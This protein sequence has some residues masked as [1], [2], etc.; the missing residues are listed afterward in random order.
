MVFSKY[1]S[2]NCGCFKLQL[3]TVFWMA[4]LFQCQCHWACLWLYSF[5]I[6]IYPFWKSPFL[7]SLGLIKSFLSCWGLFFFLF[8]Q[9]KKKKFHHVFAFVFNC[10]KI[11]FPCHAGFCPTTMWVSRN[12][13]IH[14]SLCLEPLSS[15][16]TPPL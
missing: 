15:P 9:I 5:I 3:D 8:L 11:A 7:Y 12:V 13:M 1:I 6:P 4:S 14:L 10:R 2:I 16:P